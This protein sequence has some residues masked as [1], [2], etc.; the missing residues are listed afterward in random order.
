MLASCTLRAHSLNTAHLYSVAQGILKKSV[1]KSGADYW[2]SI[3]KQITE[4]AKAGVLEA[5]P[6]EH[7]ELEEAVEPLVHC[8]GMCAHGSLKKWRSQSVCVSVCLC[9][10]LS[11]CLSVSVSP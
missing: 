9:V 2:L 4:E 5:A 1:F 3:M 8:S 7:K 10:C 6:A 11:A